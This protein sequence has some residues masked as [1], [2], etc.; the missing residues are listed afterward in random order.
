MLHSFPTRRSSD[1][2][3]ELESFLQQHPSSAWAP[4][5]H[6]QLGLACQL[7]SSYSKA[8]QYYSSA[9]ATTKDADQDPARQIALDAAGPL[10]KLLAL[11]GRLDEFDLLQA[12]ARAA[13]KEP[14]SSDWV[15]AI[16]LAR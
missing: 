16:D 10:A 15:W 11:T 8:I 5:L 13:G 14:P 2:A 3:R 1:L 6:L 12:E 7:R 4:D 9:W